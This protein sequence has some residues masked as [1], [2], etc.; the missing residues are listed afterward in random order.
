MGFINQL[1][2]SND[3]LTNLIGGTK[4]LRVY[5]RKKRMIN[6]TKLIKTLLQDIINK[7]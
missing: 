2:P 7:N 1:T 5:W 4:H 3:I 6:D